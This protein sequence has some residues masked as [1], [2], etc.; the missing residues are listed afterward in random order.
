MGRRRAPGFITTTNP[1]RATMTLNAA[2]L[3]ASLAGLAQAFPYIAL[4]SSASM[5]VGT[6]KAANWADTG[7]GVLSASSLAFTGL[8]A[9]QPVTHVLLFSA[10]TAGNPGGAIE[11]KAGDAAANA[12]GEYTLTSITLNQAEV[13]A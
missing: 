1:E 3:D 13:T 11:I 8:S 4:G 9:S 2:A 5:Q 12:A 10:A 7:N 6:R